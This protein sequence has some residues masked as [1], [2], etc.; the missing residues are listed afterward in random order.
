MLDSLEID[1]FQLFLFL[2]LDGL[3]SVQ[4]HTQILLIGFS[5]VNIGIEIMLIWKFSKLK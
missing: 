3:R 1:L 2:F 5:M 4:I